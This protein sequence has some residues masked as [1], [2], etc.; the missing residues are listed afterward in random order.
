MRKLALN[1]FFTVSK[2]L[3]KLQLKSNEKEIV[4]RGLDLLQLALENLWM[5]KGEVVEFLSD[6]TGKGKQQIEQLSLPDIKELFKEL[7]Q[8]EDIKSF[9]DFATT[10]LKNGQ[11]TS[12]SKDMDKH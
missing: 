12:S 1:D 7:S 8:Q 2:I 4:N 5:A 11:E 9:F 3:K 6:L 10:S